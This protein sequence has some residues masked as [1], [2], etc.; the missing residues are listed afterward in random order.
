MGK[1]C[2]GLGCRGESGCEGRAQ[3]WDQAEGKDTAVGLDP[4]E[5]SQ[6]WDPSEGKTQL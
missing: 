3:L 5:R 1:D 2:E 4:R 6:L